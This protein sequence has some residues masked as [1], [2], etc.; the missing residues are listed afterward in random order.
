MEDRC[1]KLNV[2]VKVVTYSLAGSMKLGPVRIL[3]GR[4]S[5][6]RAFGDIEAKVP[7]L[8]GNPK[9]LITTPEI[10]F[11]KI[12]DRTDFLLIGSDGIYEKC[13]NEYLIRTVWSTMRAQEALNKFNFHSFLGESVDMVL[14]KTIISGTLDNIS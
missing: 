7:S 14:K 5:V 9:V 1:T 10:K 13:S 12:C 3:P 8:G 4:L 11:F 2:E 6:S